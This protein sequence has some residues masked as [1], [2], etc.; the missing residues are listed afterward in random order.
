MTSGA[1]YDRKWFNR[2][3]SVLYGLD[4][5]EGNTDWYDSNGD[6]DCITKTPGEL[7]QEINES[8]HGY[9]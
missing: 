9:D 5:G 7:D 6:L 2:D 4:D 3:G 1:E 8:E